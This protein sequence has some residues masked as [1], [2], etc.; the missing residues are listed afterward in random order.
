MSNDPRPDLYWALFVLVQHLSR[1]MDERLTIVGLT[2]RQWLLLAVLSRFFPDSAPTL[3]EAAARY[4]TSRQNVK[5]IALGLERRG[6]LR[7]EPDPADGRASRLVLTDR[8][9]VFATPAL[10]QA[11]D[12]FLEAVFAGTPEPDLER[13]RRFTLDLL[14]RLDGQQE[15]P[16]GAQ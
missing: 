15:A 12:E 6:W 5:Q 11:G 10:L 3:T 8:I 13:M 4:G 9:A 1:R 14:A 2:S 7:I 16:G